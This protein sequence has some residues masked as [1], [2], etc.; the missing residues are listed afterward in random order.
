MPPVRKHFASILFLL[1]LVAI[2]SVYIAQLQSVLANDF[3]IDDAFIYSRFARNFAQ[4]SGFVWNPGE[5]PVEGFTSFL[6]LILLIVTEKLGSSSIVVMPIL[7]VVSFLA[8]LVLSWYLGETLNPGHRLENLVSLNLIGLSPIFLHWTTTGMEMPF[9][10]ALLIISALS[11]LGY[12]RHK[13]PAWVVGFSFAI[14]TLSRPE[15]LGLFAITL[16][17]DCLTRFSSKKRLLLQDTLSMVMAFVFIYVP[18]FA[19][20]WTY[21]GY[22]F[23]NTYYAKTAGIS[24]VQIGEGLLYLGRSLMYYAFAGIGVP[25]IL[26]LTRLN[27]TKWNTELSIERIYIVVFVLCCWSIVILNGGDH[28]VFGRFLMPTIPFLI[29]LIITVGFSIFL[30]TLTRNDAVKSVFLSVP[31]VIAVFDWQPWSFVS[32]DYVKTTLPPADQNKFEYFPSWDIGFIVMGKTLNAVAEEDESVAVV[33]IGAIGYYS[34]MKVIDMVG[35]VDPVI[36]H[37][38]F[39]PIYTATW[40]PGHDKGNGLYILSKHPDYIQL[41]D[42]LTSQPFAGINEHSQQYKSIVEIWASPEFHASYEFYPIQTEEG[43]YYNLYRR[44]EST[45]QREEP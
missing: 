9:Y 19:W 33:P 24:S 17:F 1:L 23:P 20:K 35:L 42:L 39:D 31:I 14:T 6:Y 32:P 36:A 43:W 8:I 41:I 26:L 5:A 22:P 44:V 30:D 34:H 10:T 45:P 16:V 28:F 4:G 27:K 7:G 15:S 29:V 2:V 37:E 38:P 18:V 25:L 21:F 13:C 40:R 3:V 12:Q 11:Y